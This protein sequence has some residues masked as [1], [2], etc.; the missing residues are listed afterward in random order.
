VNVAAGILMAQLQVSIEE[1]LLRLRAHAFR[2]HLPLTE[3][4]QAVLNRQIDL[5]RVAD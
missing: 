5:D 3:V 2:H 4:A 1:A